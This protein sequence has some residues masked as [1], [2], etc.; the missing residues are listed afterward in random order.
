MSAEDMDKVALYSFRNIFWQEVGRLSKGYNIVSKAKADKWLT[1]EDVRL[2]T[3][4]E[5]LREY[6]L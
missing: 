3:P 4:E 1:M 2:A 6:T 5:L